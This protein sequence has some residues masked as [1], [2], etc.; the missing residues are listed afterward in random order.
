MAV[1]VTTAPPGTARGDFFETLRR[2]LLP[3]ID[4]AMQREDLVIT[5]STMI[6]FMLTSSLPLSQ[7]LLRVLLMVCSRLV[8]LAQPLDKDQS[9]GQVKVKDT[10]S[11]QSQSQSLLKPLFEPL[12]LRALAQSR[13]W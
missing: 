2:Q 5:R 7:I 11:H 9:N 10:H 1:L 4:I 3:A 12:L 8:G 6:S 13:F